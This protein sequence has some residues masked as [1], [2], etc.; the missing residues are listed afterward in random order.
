MNIFKLISILIIVGFAGCSNKTARTII[1]NAP[2]ATFDN[3]ESFLAESKIY[4]AKYYKKM[5]LENND[6]INIINIMSYN[7][8]IP[9]DQLL[10][11]VQEQKNASNKVSLS[12]NSIYALI[13]DSNKN[14]LY[15]ASASFFTKTPKVYK[16]YALELSM[17]KKY[18]EKDYI[19]YIEYLDCKRYL[20]GCKKSGFDLYRKIGDSI[21][22]V[23]SI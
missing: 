12:A 5:S 7:G 4:I 9:C 15:K 6:F 3:L 21:E 2:T 11:R 18:Y 20:I 16:P 8:K 19:A 10:D 14:Y 17:I 23:K 1:N 22:F 13:I